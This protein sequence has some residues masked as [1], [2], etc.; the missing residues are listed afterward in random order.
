MIDE[1]DGYC[2]VQWFYAFNS[3]QKEL[4]MIELWLLVANGNE[5]NRQ[6]L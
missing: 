5:G 1:L 4:S 2:T 6:L 3:N